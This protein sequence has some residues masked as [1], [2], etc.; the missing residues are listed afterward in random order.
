[1]IP[2]NCLQ[3]H[4]SRSIIAVTHGVYLVLLGNDGEAGCRDGELVAIVFV[5]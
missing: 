4:D 3:R 5:E 1:M 2:L